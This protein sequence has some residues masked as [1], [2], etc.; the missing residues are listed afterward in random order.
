[1]SNA[2]EL[3]KITVSAIFIYFIFIYYLVSKQSL[4]EHIGWER[5]RFKSTGHG[6]I[7]KK[8][9]IKN[10]GTRNPTLQRIYHFVL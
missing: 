3:S 6:M 4:V 10:V 2:W 1:M 5:F 8:V 9:D 7:P